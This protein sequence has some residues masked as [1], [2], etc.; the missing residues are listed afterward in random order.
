MRKVGSTTDTADS[1]GEWTN[2]NVANGIPPTIINAEMLNTFQ[3]ELV[4]VVEGAGM[5]LDPGDDEQVLQAL[6]KMFLGRSNPFGDI[7]S[8]GTTKTALENL[9]L[10]DIAL[11]GVST[12]ALGSAGYIA[13]PAV[14]GGVKR[15]LILQFGLT[16]A[17]TA[18][19]GS[20]YTCTLPTAF[21]TAFQRIF[22]CHDNPIDKGVG[23]ASASVKTLSTFS[24]R[25]IKISQT[26][27]T[28][29][30]ENAPASFHYL[31]IGYE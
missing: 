17:V 31:A 15:R 27:T 12:G 5:E 26:G 28:L 19:E 8:D 20:D 13:F 9:G 14:I 3:R 6:T 16:P 7:K 4:A 23:F 24:F 18:G 10:G 30:G 11:A 29:F 22:L 2:G 25:P 21:P 1:K